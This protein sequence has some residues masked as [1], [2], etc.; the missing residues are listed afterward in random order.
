MPGTWSFTAVMSGTGPSQVRP[1][2]KANG[3]N[4]ATNYK[5]TQSSFLEADDHKILSLLFIGFY[6]VVVLVRK[7][8]IVY[9]ARCGSIVY[10]SFAILAEFNIPFFDTRYIPLLFACSGSQAPSMVRCAN[11][12][13][14]HA[15]A[16][17][18]SF[19]HRQHQQNN[20]SCNLATRAFELS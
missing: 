20:R 1:C 9:A 5:K 8:T 19:W 11:S 14:I 6:G 15:R 10:F 4:L 17:R 18:K 3:S 16:L 13:C 7:T 2:S 12:G